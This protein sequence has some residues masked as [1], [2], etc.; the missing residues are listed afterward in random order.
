MKFWSL[1]FPRLCAILENFSAAND[2]IFVNMLCCI[3]RSI[4]RQ[5]D[6][7]VIPL[8]I[9]LLSLYVIELFYSDYCSIFFKI[10][11]EY[12]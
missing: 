11:L 7:L 12:G 10:T 2:E 5:A 8:R 3:E 4:R 1:V 9:S 6:Q